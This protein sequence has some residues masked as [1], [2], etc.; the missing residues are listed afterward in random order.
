MLDRD[1]YNFRKALSEVSPNLLGVQG[2]IALIERE[3]ASEAK[4]SAKNQ[5]TVLSS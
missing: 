5:G 3:V 2:V 4:S 1:G